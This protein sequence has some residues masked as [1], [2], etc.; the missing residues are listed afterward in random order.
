MPSEQPARQ[1]PKYNGRVLGLDEKTVRIEFDSDKKF[2]YK[3]PETSTTSSYTVRRI[4]LPHD[5][6]IRPYLNGDNT[7]RDLPH[8]LAA[9]GIVAEIMRQRAENIVDGMGWQDHRRNFDDES[10]MP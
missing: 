2:K 10:D 3:D 1:E 4:N 6:R 8:K 5:D 7:I 9:K